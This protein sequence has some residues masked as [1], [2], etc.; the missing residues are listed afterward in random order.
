ME[1]KEEIIKLKNNIKMCE[2]K[3]QTL[4]DILI[5][6]GIISRTDFEENLES[7]FNRKDD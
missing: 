5:K 1:S 6:E 2:I 7:I 4:L 3:I